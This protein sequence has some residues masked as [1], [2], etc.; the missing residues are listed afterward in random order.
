MTR[1]RQ[2]FLYVGTT[3]AVIFGIGFTNLGQSA[4]AAIKAQLVRDA[5]NPA[6]NPYGGGISNTG[7]AVVLPTSTPDGQAVKRIVLEFVSGNCTTPDSSTFITSV[8]LG[9]L[10]NSGGAYHNFVPTL[11]YS[12][13]N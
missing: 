13:V 10:Q 2:T 4:T 9:V 5:D 3:V 11:T 8:E 1:L 12:G 7:S 6:N